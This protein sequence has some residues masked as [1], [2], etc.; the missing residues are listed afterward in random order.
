MHITIDS[1]VNID[2]IPSPYLPPPS[3]TSSFPVTSANV[4]ISPN[5]Y[6]NQS[7]SFNPFAI[8]V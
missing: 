4:G 2:P 8:L 5:S 6:Y 1:N 3:S 7:F